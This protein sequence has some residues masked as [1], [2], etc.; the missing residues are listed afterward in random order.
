[1][2]EIVLA[3]IAGLVV[4]LL[5]AFIKLPIPSPPTISG[6]MGV[7]GIFSGYQIYVHFWG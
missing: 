2:Q 7:V 6:V 5:F 4:G 3:L 1:M